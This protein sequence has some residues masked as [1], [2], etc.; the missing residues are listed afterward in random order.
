MAVAAAVVGA[1]VISA[2]MQNE[3]SKRASASARRAQEY[4]SKR[5]IREE[6]RQFNEQIKRYDAIREQLKPYISAGETALTSQLK[7][8][9][10]AGAE[11]QEQEI[12]ILEASPLFQS[13]VEQ[14]ESSLLQKASA[15]GG[16]RGGNIQARIGSV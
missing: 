12:S 10:L 15:T 8:A 3:A 16:I 1:A 9:G 13:L 2:Y 6:K 5:A 4:M 11:E 14:G 7:L